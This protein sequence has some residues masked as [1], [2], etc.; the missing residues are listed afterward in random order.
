MITMIIQRPLILRRKPQRVPLL[1]TP[2]VSCNMADSNA[3]SANRCFTRRTM[4]CCDQ[5]HRNLVRSTIQPSFEVKLIPIDIYT[6]LSRS[7]AP[8]T[9]RTEL[10]RFRGLLHPRRSF[11]TKCLFPSATRHKHY[12]AITHHLGGHALRA[13]RDRSTNRRY[14]PERPR[15]AG[16]GLDKRHYRAK[17]RLRYYSRARGRG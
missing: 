13:E 14:C 5:T 11:D 12:L 4:N 1:T 9:L 17:D 15:S 2:N 7:M 16:P 6:L 3:G 10:P 8:Y